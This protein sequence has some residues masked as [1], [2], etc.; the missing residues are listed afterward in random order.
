MAP[1]YQRIAARAGRA[2]VHVTCHNFIFIDWKTKKIY[3]HHSYKK[4]NYTE[5]YIP[6]ANMMVVL[7]SSL[8]SKLRNNDGIS[9]YNGDTNWATPRIPSPA[10]LTIL[11][12]SSGTLSHVSSFRLIWPFHYCLTI[13]LKCCVNHCHS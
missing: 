9:A 6:M 10:L 11:S 2:E 12:P 1:I 8:I 5:I 3:H 7:N 13:H 4:I